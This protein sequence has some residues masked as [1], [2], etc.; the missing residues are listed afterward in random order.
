MRL[1]ASAND[2]VNRARR[3]TFDTPYAAGFVDDGNQ[4][5]RLDAI[6]RIEGQPWA[7]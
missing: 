5:W 7:M 4:R 2:G 6:V 1:L 3:Q